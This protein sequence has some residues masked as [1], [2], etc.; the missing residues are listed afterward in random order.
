MNN[1]IY[2]DGTSALKLTYENP[3][4]DAPRRS[5]DVDEVV[6]FES[7]VVSL[8]GNQQ[9]THEHRFEAEPTCVES[10]LRDLKGTSFA[11]TKSDRAFG[12]VV[13]VLGFASAFV[14]SFITLV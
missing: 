14:F 10:A 5:H 12:A 1:V 8:P 9:G 2:I 4:S 6:P 7:R 13:A 11:Q 3:I